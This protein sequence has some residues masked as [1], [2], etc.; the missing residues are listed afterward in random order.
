MGQP[1]VWRPGDI[2]SVLQAASK[3]TGTVPEFLTHVGDPLEAVGTTVKDFGEAVKDVGEAVK[4]VAGT[5]LG[6]GGIP[7]LVHEGVDAA[8]KIDAMVEHHDPATQSTPGDQSHDTGHPTDPNHDTGNAPQQ[9]DHT[10]NQGWHKPP[11]HTPSAPDGSSADTGAKPPP[12]TQTT[13]LD[14]P[15]VQ[16]SGYVPFNLGP[17]S[18]TAP[19]AYTAI[20]TPVA[21]VTNPV[22]RD[23]HRSIRPDALADSGKS[24]ETR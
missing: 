7:G 4:D 24:P 16:A 3:I 23:K 11:A 9:P 14:V 18:H 6:P 10:D 8:Q 19:A 13:Q 1:G 21:M 17:A 2:A 15:P 12:T 20:P 22:D 5:F